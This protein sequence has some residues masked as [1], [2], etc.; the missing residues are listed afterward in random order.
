MAGGSSYLDLNIDMIAE[1]SEARTLVSDF[2]A[3]NEHLLIEEGVNLWKVLTL[4][5]DSNIK[6]QRKLKEIID[7]HNIGDII[8][9]VLSHR[10]CMTAL[11][12]QLSC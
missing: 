4:A 5:R 10:E 3:I 12:G 6:M 1:S 11:E 7:T 8:E 2:L 9:G